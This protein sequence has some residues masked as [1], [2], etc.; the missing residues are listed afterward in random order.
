MWQTS[1]GDGILTGFLLPGDFNLSN[2]RR[3]L[4]P[5]QCANPLL[6]V[7]SGLWH[8]TGDFSRARKLKPFV[9]RA[10]AWQEKP[11]V[12]LSFGDYRK[13][14]CAAHINQAW[15]PFFPL[16]SLD[17]GKKSVKTAAS[18]KH[19]KQKY[20]FL[21]LCFT[22]RL[23]PHRLFFF[24]NPSIPTSRSFCFDNWYTSL[25]RFI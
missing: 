23:W 21:P 22:L 19:L 24:F 25:S 10:S 13:R 9:F 8:D 1:L 14:A 20:V 17:S 11:P 6:K 4:C 2:Q 5:L 7:E 15:K 16:S 12:H 18:S 3:I